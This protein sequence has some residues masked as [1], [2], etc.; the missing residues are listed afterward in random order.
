MHNF[1]QGDWF[2]GSLTNE[3]TIVEDNEHAQFLNTVY[4]GFP[5]KPW[6]P[7]KDE[8]VFNH[9][10][11][12]CRVEK[13]REDDSKQIL[14]APIALALNYEYVNACDC[15]PFIGKLPKF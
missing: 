14:V 2:V 9:R 5:I 11:G 1:K 15:Q 8:Y 10:Y 7:K 3:P 13:Y 12:L 6:K 4:N